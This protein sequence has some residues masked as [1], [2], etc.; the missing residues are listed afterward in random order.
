MVLGQRIKKSRKSKCISQQELANICGIKRSM[1]SRFENNLSYPTIKTLVEIARAL[2]KTTDYLVG[3]YEDNSVDST[4][5]SIEEAR[6]KDFYSKLLIVEE[7]EVNKIIG[8][9]KLLNT[10]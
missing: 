1:L 7:N 2:N 6:L 4:E 8:I 3:M 5:Q 9:W 10:K